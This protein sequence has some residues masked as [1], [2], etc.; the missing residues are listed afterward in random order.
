[1]TS[2]NFNVG[3][4]G[5]EKAV[6]FLQSKGYAILERNYKTKFGEIDIIAQETDTIVFVEVKARNTCSFGTPEEQISWNKQQRIMKI[7]LTYLKKNHLEN[8]PVRFDVVS[9][10]PD[11]IELIKNAFESGGNY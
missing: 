11:K 8:R 6:L 2:Q 4:E 5:E 7:A 9:I 3:M 10:S 1:M